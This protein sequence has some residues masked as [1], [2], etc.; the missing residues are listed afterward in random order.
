MTNDETSR[1]AADIVSAKWQTVLAYADHKINPATTR[2]AYAQPRLR[3]LFPVVSHGVLYLNRC[4]GFPAPADVPVVYRL[5][6]GGFQVVRESDGVNLGEPTTLEE[7]FALVVA[8]LPEGCG[9]AIIG[10]AD[11]L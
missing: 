2:A 6:G 4:T 3:E 7:A 11:D 10:T 9:P 8:N 1:D 5:S